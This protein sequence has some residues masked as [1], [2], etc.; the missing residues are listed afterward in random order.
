MF[1]DFAVSQCLALQRSA[2]LPEDEY[3]ELYISLRWSEGRLLT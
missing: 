3:V 1:I 2:M